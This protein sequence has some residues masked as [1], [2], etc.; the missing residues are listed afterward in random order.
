MKHLDMYDI[1]IDAQH[2]F[3]KSRSCE[4]QLIMTVQDLANSL[5]RNEQV[6][7]ILPWCSEAW[8]I[9]VRAGVNSWCNSFRKRPDMLSGPV[10]MCGFKADKRLFIPLGCI[11]NTNML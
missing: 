3:R 11:C 4:S 5:N 8:T 1:L 7:G 6:D 9:K 10:A 2:G